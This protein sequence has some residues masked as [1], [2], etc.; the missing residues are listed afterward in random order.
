MKLEWIIDPETEGAS[1]LISM[2]Q[3]AADYAPVAE[4][5]RCACSA[6]VRLC[7]DE[8]IREIN[9]QMRGIDRSTDVLSFPSV[10][11]PDE[12]TAGS[13]ENLIRREYDDGMDACFLGDIVISVEHIRAQAKEFGHSEAREAAYLLIHGICHLMG[14][15]HMKEEERKR[16][17]QKE[18][19]ILSAVGMQRDEVAGTPD[20]ESLIRLAKEAQKR[21]Y[22]PYSGFSVG[23]ALLSEDGRVFQGC[24]IENASYGVG[25]CAERT[26]LFKAVSE[27]A[28][29]FTAIAIAADT[30]AWPC[31]ACRQVL[32]EFAPEI[33][34]LVADSEGRVE[35]MN[36]REL[37][38]NSFGPE[39]LSGKK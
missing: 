14:Y 22:S 8:Q 26:A 10:Q 18:E 35:E 29:S 21:S 24:N 23:A 33:R 20:D 4:G 9:L 7:N 1:S 36:L 17:R 6:T 13:C 34:V 12:R 30:M 2:M 28:R 37:L 11:Y 25:I 31:G 27:G 19:E 32:N 5:I 16:M 15:D 39:E 38:P 3:T